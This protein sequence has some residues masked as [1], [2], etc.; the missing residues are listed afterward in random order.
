MLCAC[1]SDDT[2][3]PNPNA[4]PHWEFLKV[5]NKWTYEFTDYDDN[6]CITNKFVGTEEIT[7]INGDFINIKWSG[8]NNTSNYKWYA[9]E[10]YFSDYYND[11]F[12]V[13][14]Y[15]NSYVGQKWKINIGVS[16]PWWADYEVVSINEIIT[17]PAG[18]FYNIIKIK[19]NYISSEMYFYYSY[20]YGII[21]YEEYG[22]SD[23]IICPSLDLL[24]HFLKNRFRYNHTVIFHFSV[25]N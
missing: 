24:L 18:I 16:S 15:K 8:N 20:G 6:G 17:V 4:H 11:S 3:N 14:L 1:N 2:N 22:I 19:A 10:G 9:N 7:S 21:K 5:G 23:E 12:Y 13:S 25:H